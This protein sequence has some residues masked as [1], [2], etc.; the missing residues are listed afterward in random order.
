MATLSWRSARPAAGDRLRLGISPIILKISLTAIGINPTEGSSSQQGRGRPAARGRS[1]AS[2]LRR[3]TACGSAAGAFLRMG[4]ISQMSR[5]RA[6]P[7]AIG[8]VERADPEILLTV[9]SGKS[10]RP[11]G[12]S[13]I[14]RA[15]GRPTG[16]ICRRRRSGS[17]AR[18]VSRGSIAATWSA[19][20]VSADRR[21][22]RPAKVIETADRRERGH[23]SPA[24]ADLDHA[25][26]PR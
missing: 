2:G 7:R 9:K 5:C 17:R 6:E 15:R 25:S 13:A 18:A 1:P 20:P 4:K 16:L 22:S 19:G 21:R 23:S 10:R 8:A 26:L 11:S 24:G 14:P 12:T 3:R